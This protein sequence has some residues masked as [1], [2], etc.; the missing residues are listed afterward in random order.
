MA[1]IL[2]VCDDPALCALL[3]SSLAGLGH[4]ADTAA[5][6]N[7]ALTQ[8][9]LHAPDLL[10]LAVPTLVR[11]EWSFIEQLRVKMN[12]T[13]LPLIVIIDAPDAKGVQWSRELAVSQVISRAGKPQAELLSTLQKA[14][15]KIL[16]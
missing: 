13:Q 15:E 14:L 7:S 12:R 1:R 8:L 9:L 6:D 10:I 11:D 16:I 4:K 2:L 3:S 5:N